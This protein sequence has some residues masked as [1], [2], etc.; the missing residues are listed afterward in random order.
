MGR[1][2]QWVGDVVTLGW[3][4][5]CWREKHPRDW[6]E[7]NSCLGLY[8]PSIAFLHHGEPQ[9]FFEPSDP[10]ALLPMH[11]WA[12]AELIM[13]PERERLGRCDR[14][15]RFYVSLGW[16]RRKRYCSWGCAHA[17]AASRYVGRCYG[18][19]RKQRLELARRLLPH[20]RPCDGDWKAWLVKEAQLVKEPQADTVKL[21]RNFLTRCEFKRELTAPL[22]KKEGKL[23]A[24]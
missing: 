2:R 17:V 20:W 9:Y 14:C 13:N 6:H 24:G 7:I 12:F 3:D 21:T 11:W 18:E 15:G 16:Y 19:Y 10:A 22:P 4:L 23:H 5:R 1:V 8:R